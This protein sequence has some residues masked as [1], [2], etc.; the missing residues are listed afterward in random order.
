MMVLSAACGPDARVA[1]ELDEVCGAP[2]PV[3]ILELDDATPLASVRVAGEVGDRRLFHIRTLDTAAADFGAGAVSRSSELWS[4]GTCGASPVRLAAAKFLRPMQLEHLPDHAFTCDPER[5]ELGVVDPEGRRATRVVFRAEGCEFHAT[6]WGLV[7][8]VP[9]DDDTG[10]LVLQPYPAD[11]WTDEPAAI[12]LL[13]PVAV[14]PVP[15]Q[16]F[17]RLDQVLAVADDELLV[18]DTDAR[19][20]HLSLLD[21]TTEV[22]ASEVRELAASPDLRWVAWQGAAITND[23]DAWPAGAIHVLDRQAEQTWEFPDT[24][25]AAVLGSPLA[26][27]DRG[28]VQL[29]YLDG[30]GT[31]RLFRL[32]TLASID[33]PADT[34]ILDAL[35]DGELLVS[36]FVGRAALAAMD[37]DTGAT[38]VLSRAGGTVIDQR[39]DGLELIEGLDCCIVD[40]IRDEAPLFS[41]GFDGARE[42]L[43]RRVTLAPIRLSDDRVVTRLDIDRHWRGD[44]IV[45]DPEGLEEQQVDDAVIADPSSVGDR[46]LLYGVS[47]DE[48]TGVWLARI[49]AR[50]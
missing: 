34:L 30:R 48:R 36:A 17:S 24:S 39:D 50:E 21:G 42:R 29:A 47:D 31:T 7:T 32:P 13:D 35:P 9:H 46:T 49:A 41:I 6:P 16:Q 2:S 11:P 4:V 25:L 44:L 8:I 43:A 19:L 3:R 18:V 40:D 37:P 26:F 1:A 5:G 20:V 23:D 12:T 33:L 45:V 14:R 38:R 15:A 22:V 10:A 27:I 28:Y